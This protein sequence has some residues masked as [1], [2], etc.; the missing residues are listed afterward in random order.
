VSSKDQDQIPLEDLLTTAGREG[1]SRAD[2]S[3]APVEERSTMEEVLEDD[4]TRARLERLREGDSTASAGWTPPAGERLPMKGQ[5]D[6]GAAAAPLSTLEELRSPA[7]AGHRMGSGGSDDAISATEPFNPETSAVARMALSPT[8]GGSAGVSPVHGAGNPTDAAGARFSLGEDEPLAKGGTSPVEA[9]GRTT[10]DAGARV[11]I[12][13]EESITKGGTSPVESAGIPTSDAT[14]RFALGEPEAERPAGTSPLEAAGSPSGAGQ[15]LLRPDSSGRSAPG[16]SSVESAGN[17]SDSADAR[18]PVGEVEE[19]APTGGSSLE[20][21]G[22]P[23]DQAAS[24]FPVWPVTSVAKDVR[25]MESVGSPAQDASRRIGLGEAPRRAANAA[26]SLESVGQPSEDPADRR[27]FEPVRAGPG[28]PTGETYGHPSDNADNRMG[29]G[30]A[31]GT[32]DAGSSLGGAGRTTSDVGQRVGRIEPEELEGA[33]PLESAGNPTEDVAAR[34]GFVDPFEPLPASGLSGADSLSINANDRVKRSE[35]RQGGRAKGTDGLA[36]LGAVPV[37]PGGTN[38]FRREEVSQPPPVHRPG[39]DPV[40]PM[41]VRMMG[42]LSSEQRTALGDDPRHIGDRTEERLDFIH[43]RFER[44]Q[45]ERPAYL[46]WDDPLGTPTVAELPRFAAGDVPLG[47]GMLAQLLASRY[48]DDLGLDQ[49]QNL[50]ARIHKP[51][52]RGRL[53]TA[54]ARASALIQPVLSQMWDELCAAKKVEVSQ[55]GHGAMHVQPHRQDPGRVKAAGD[56]RHVVFWYEGPGS[57][58]PM[59]QL[60]GKTVD[61]LADP[62]EVFGR[63]M[64]TNVNGHWAHVR[65]RFTMALVSSPEDARRLLFACHNLERARAV[66]PREMPEAL[67]KIKKQ[68]ED[69]RADKPQPEGAFDFAVHYA[70]AL[71]PRLEQAE[72]PAGG[73]RPWRAEAVP[74]YLDEADAPPAESL[75]WYSLV[76]S[77][78]RLGRRPWTY[79]HD[80]FDA[81]GTPAG[82]KAKDWTP[83]AWAKRQP[84]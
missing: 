21:A 44:L 11:A 47:N 39:I 34:F 13:E 25:S 6:R 7:D 31:V 9:A 49:Q 70:L 74:W 61:G 26:G 5:E 72:V 69:S 29:F 28:Q 84:S 20:S 67:A 83:A 56:A 51:M 17:P 48:H 64:E 19:E 38:R 50:L 1:R 14:A 54:T 65:R 53:R 68:L 76:Q 73:N 66:A 4:G 23:S 33:S 81:I 36:G 77:C 58:S 82:I 32:A 52:S 79:L 62:D 59:G 30:P 60:R 18:I 80:L 63:I 2:K 35:P 55:T 3:A 37:L 15:R 45:V 12:R 8:E 22:Q 57:D 42:E 10:S 40:S 78:V 41:V 71:W 27:A 24:A 43:Y 16:G 46:P 75:T